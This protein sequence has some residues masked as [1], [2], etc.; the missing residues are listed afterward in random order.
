MLATSPIIAILATADAARAREYYE[1][2]LGLRL[3]ADDPFALVFDAAGTTL[4]IAK[5]Q[6]TAPP[7]YSVLGWRVDDIAA[8]VTSLRERGVTFERYPGMDQDEAGVWASPGG[9]KVAWFHDPDGNL[10]SLTQG[11]DA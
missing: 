5:V 11:P 7:P 8:T 9:G 2:T 3:V 10:L 6:K 4:R 1:R